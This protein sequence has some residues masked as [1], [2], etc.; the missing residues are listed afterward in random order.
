M[1]G[2][3]QIHYAGLWPRFLALLVDLIILSAIFFPTTKIVKGT[4]MMSAGEHE[5]H[6]SLFITDPLCII[7]LCAIVLYFV[8]FEGLAGATPGKFIVGIRVINLDG[9]KPGLAKGAIRNLLRLVDGL[10]ALN[11]LGI[12]LIVSSPERTRFGDRVAGTRVV[13]K[14]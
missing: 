1:A 13:Y 11:I 12:V 4:W 14:P 9:A 6:Y 10:P 5:W 7:F 3:N 2:V 8:F